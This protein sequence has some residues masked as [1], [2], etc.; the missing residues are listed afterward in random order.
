[1]SGMDNSWVPEATEHCVCVVCGCD[2]QVEISTKGRHRVPVRNVACASCGLVYVSPR[3]SPAAM[4]E[5]YRSHYRSQ[6][7]IPM[8]TKD[9][10]MAQPGTPEFEQALLHRAYILAT[11]ALGNGMVKAGDRVLDV[12][13]RRGDALVSMNERV[14]IEM[15]GIEPGQDSAREAGLRGVEIHAG[16]METYEPGEMR[17]DQIQIFHVLEHLHDPLA[18]LVLLRSWLKPNG[19]LV[20]DVPDAMQPY[21]GLSNFFQYPHLY[22]FSERCMGAL[23]AR[24]GLRVRAIGFGPTLFMVAS[25]LVD[26]QALPKVYRPEMIGAR[27]PNGSEVNTWLQLYDAFERLHKL[28]LDGHR[29]ESGLVC[30]LLAL[31]GLPSKTEGGLPHAVVG[32]V[33]SMANEWIRSGRQDDAVAILRAGREGPHGPAAK[34]VFGEALAKLAGLDTALGQRA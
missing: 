20:I 16:V 23:L 30:R 4:E 2:E 15:H 3:P 14:P 11:N 10:T 33:M 1:M 7:L 8:P 34:Q 25:P 28:V 17:F 5:F 19:R 9:G 12:G 24:A 31:K 13:C 6:H 22:S 29:V 18:A 27:A 32:T 21:G 26:E